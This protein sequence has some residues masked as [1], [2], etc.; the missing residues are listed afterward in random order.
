MRIASFNANSLLAQID[1]IRSH[2]SEKFFHAKERFIDAFLVEFDK[3]FHHYTNVIITGD[4]NC[5]LNRQNFEA[6]YLR[7]LIYM[8]HKLLGLEYRLQIKTFAK[9]VKIYR[10][11]RGCDVNALRNNVLS[12]LNNALEH[13]SANP[14]LDLY[15]E[16]LCRSIVTALDDLAPLI[17]REVGKPP[18]GWLTPELKCSIKLRNKTYAAAKRLNS[19]ELFSQ[20]LVIRRQVKHDIK[21]AKNLYYKERLAKLTSPN[22]IWAE[23]GRQGLIAINTESSSPLHHF[24]A[25]QLNTY[26]S[27]VT[28]AHSPCSASE[29]ALILTQQPSVNSNFA[30]FHVTDQQVSKI[31]KSFLTSSRGQSPDGIKLIHIRDLLSI[32]VPR[33]TD[34][35]NASMSSCLFPTI[36]KTA[37]IIPLS[38]SYPPRS[39]SDTRPVANLSH[40]VK[41]LERLVSEQVTNFLDQNNI[42]DPVQ[43]GFRKHHST[44]TA[45]L[46]VLDDARKA[47]DDRCITVLLMVDFS[48]AFDSINQRLLLTKLKDYGFSNE[49]IEWFQSYLT[50]RTLSVQDLSGHHSTFLPNSSGM[51]QGSVLRPL[52]FLIFINDVGLGLS[53]IT[54]A[55]TKLNL[56]AKSVA[57]WART[58]GLKLNVSKTKAII[59]GSS[60]YVEQLKHQSKPLI[61]IDGKAV[62]FV[63]TVR[64]L[65]VH[66]SADLSWN[67]HVAQVSRK[68]YAS[69]YRLKH[70]GDMLSPQVKAMLVHALIMPYTDYSSLVY[71][72]ATEYL[73]LKLQTLTTTF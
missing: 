55:I 67:G 45:I 24:S 73:N 7:D 20:F 31:L 36:W 50:G 58:N 25:D 27:S 34:L 65:G 16:M 3:F 48:R 43:A 5:D 56:D 63:D 66:I 13:I 68:V 64:N 21:R 17:T 40:V 59:L 19:N 72:D 60:A 49:A 10:D 44:Q 14:D 29:Q 11:F 12:T 38:K 35:F 41:V 6:D 33:L 30:F 15:T 18:A 23:L 1:L 2:F 71:H 54:E 26:Y 4:S 8:G 57:D 70:R 39:E 32:L 9:S 42:L 69:L 61:I 28:S 47:V 62:P 51:L 52:L 37:Y 53:C 22:S 46:K